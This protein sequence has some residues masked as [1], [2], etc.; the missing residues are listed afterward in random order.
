MTRRIFNL[1]QILI[2]VVLYVLSYSVVLFSQTLP[3]YHYT[4]SDGLASSSVYDLIQDRNGYIWLATA[5]GVSKFDGHHFINYS[6]KDGLNSSNIINLIEGPGGEI[7]F[8]N[9]ENS[10]NVFKEGK[11]GMLGR[12]HSKETLE[13]MRNNNLC[14]S[15]PMFNRT[16]TEKAR[17]NISKNHRFKKQNQNV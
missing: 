13:K 4:S 17:K 11:I 7:F 2:T 14:S 6:T 16:H 12:K 15:N 3:Y 8:G 10:I 9:I 5:N 1:S